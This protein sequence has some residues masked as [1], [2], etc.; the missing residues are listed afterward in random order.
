MRTM[1]P[2]PG[3]RSRLVLLPGDEL[4][5]H[6]DDAEGAR[7]A[8]GESVRA[9]ISTHPDVAAALASDLILNLGVDGDDDYDSEPIGTVKRALA[10]MFVT[11]LGTIEPSI[12]AAG[13]NASEEMRTRLFDV[14]ELA[15]RWVD[16]DD[17]RRDAGDAQIPIDRVRETFDQL[18]TVAF[19]RLSGDWGGN[20]AFSGASLIEELSRTRPE[21]S[22]QQLES[23]L[24]AFLS[25]VGSMSEP[26]RPNLIMPFEPVD[27]NAALTEFARRSSYS[28]A[29]HRLL[30][31]VEHA[32]GADP[33]NVC[34][35]ITQVIAEQRDSERGIDVV[36]RLIPL[37]GKVARVHG[38]EPGVLRSV[39]PTL[40]T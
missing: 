34:T 3:S 14:Y 16:R 24:G 35:A 9:L 36:W 28:S 22:I 33:L 26:P 21:W 5:P 8:A 25:A 18:L 38:G 10:T 37:L 31:A 23:I 15:G 19:T 12:E 40:H 6:G 27:P 2:P 4:R 11:G 1:L 7:A 29:A 20:V 17:S 32:A 39:L 13:R 30:S